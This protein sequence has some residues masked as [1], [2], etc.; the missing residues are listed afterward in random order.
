[1]PGVVAKAPDCKYLANKTDSGSQST[2]QRD[3]GIHLRREVLGREETRRDK[4]L[5]WMA[6]AA[7]LADG[8]SCSCSRQGWQPLSQGL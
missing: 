3:G 1:M 5:P 8:E 4:Q 2:E 6:R 7:K